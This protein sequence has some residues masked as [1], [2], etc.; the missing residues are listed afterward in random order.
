MSARF[1]KLIFTLCCFALLWTPANQA[2]AQDP[3]RGGAAA[4]TLAV[5][6]RRLSEIL[7]FKRVLSG[8]SRLIL[9]E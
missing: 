4:T 3:P 1:A 5:E 7:S 2:W 8:V 9:R 6:V